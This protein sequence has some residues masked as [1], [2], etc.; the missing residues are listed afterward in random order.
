MFVVPHQLFSVVARDVQPAN[1][2]VFR[3]LSP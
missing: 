1:V 2:R 3:L